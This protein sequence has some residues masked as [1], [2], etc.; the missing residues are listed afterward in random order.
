MVSALA[1]T[2]RGHAVVSQARRSL[3]GTLVEVREALGLGQLGL[4]LARI[5]NALN[6]GA[7]NL[8][9]QSK[10]KNRARNKHKKGEKPGKVQEHAG[11]EGT[12]ELLKTYIKHTPFMKYDFKSRKGKASVYRE[13]R[14]GKK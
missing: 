5:Q 11:F 2:T 3:R 13:Q 8:R 6:N 1:T 14:Q 12:D 7:C 4:A 10:K 9:V